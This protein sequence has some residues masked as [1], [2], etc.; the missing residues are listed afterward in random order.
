VTILGYSAE[1]ALGQNLHRLLAP[2][3][4]LRQHHAAFPEFRRSGQGAAIGKTLELPAKGKNG[5]EIT[6]ELSLSAVALKDGW[7]A[8]GILRDITE[9]VRPGSRSPRP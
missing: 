4:H 6:V 3:V 8:I 7:N 9:P 5:Q 1:E 2:E